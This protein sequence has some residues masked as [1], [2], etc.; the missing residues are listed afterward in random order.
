MQEKLAPV[1]AKYKELED[2]QVEA[3]AKDNLKFKGDAKNKVKTKAEP[4]WF[5]N[6][7]QEFL[8]LLSFISH[9]RNINIYNF[10]NIEYFHTFEKSVLLYL[11]NVYVVTS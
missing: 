11:T 6:G 8:L 5:E 10:V 7:K 2:A 3:G 1:R 9:G 4:Y